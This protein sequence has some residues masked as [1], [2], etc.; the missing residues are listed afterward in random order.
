MTDAERLVILDAVH[1][2]DR[3]VLLLLADLKPIHADLS[4]FEPTFEAIADLRQLLT[5]LGG[6]AE[7][8][9]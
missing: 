9:Q 5:D 1:R 6:P 4:K 7:G 2:L 3:M 8:S